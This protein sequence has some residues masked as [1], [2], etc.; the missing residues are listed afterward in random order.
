MSA[1]KKAVKKIGKVIKKVWKPLLIAAAIV[2]TAGAAAG[3][4]VAMKGAFA[5]KGVIGGIGATMKA[6]AAAIGAVVKGGGIAGAK[7]AAAGSFKAA[8][9]V[10]KG[11]ATAGKL[12]TTGSKI[13]TTTAKTAA[14]TGK[15]ATTAATATGKAATA[16]TTAGKATTA[17]ATTGKAAAGTTAAG[18]GTTL[19]GTAGKTGATT[20]GTQAMMQAPTQASTGGFFNSLAGQA[21]VGGGLQAAT[22]LLAGQ[23]QDDAEMKPLSYWGRDA[24]DGTGGVRPDQVGWNPANQYGSSGSWGAPSNARAL[25]IDPNTIGVG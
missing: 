12:A 17:A 22:S 16:A 7:T 5:A 3:G 21:L 13:A 10:A 8:G 6:G 2:F 18:K 23:A 15:A 19:L 20:F 25:M 9:A 1:V 24:R 14:T 4:L 11:A